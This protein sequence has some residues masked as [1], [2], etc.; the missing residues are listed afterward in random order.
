MLAAYRS[1][2]WDRARNMCEAMTGIWGGELKGYYT[3]MAERTSAKSPKD[4]DGVYRA[5]SK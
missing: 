5:T 2:D 3:M 4:F 1:G